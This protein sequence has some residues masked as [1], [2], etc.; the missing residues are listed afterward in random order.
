MQPLEFDEDLCE[1]EGVSPGDVHTADSDWLDDLA[2]FLRSDVMS[3]LLVMIGV[4]CLI[5]EL[6]MPGA[7]V[8]GVIAAVCFVLFFWSESQVAGQITWLA[9]LLFLL[10]LI[11]IGIEVFLV[12]GTGVCGVSGVLLT[13]GGLAV[14]AFGSWP[15]T[16]SDWMGFGHKLWPFSVGIIASVF[17]AV[18]AVRYLKHIPYSLASLKA[19]G[20]AGRTARRRLRTASARV[21][22]AARPRPRGGDAAA[23]GR[24]D[25]VRRAIRGR[26]R[27]GRL[28][29]L[30]RVCR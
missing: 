13:V 3:V 9:V 4:T 22:L 6:K 15:Q 30:G 10:G 8:P 16:T 1:T 24:Q 7:S 28:F 26:G 14:V 2:D 11:L 17:V 20:E 21:G 29:P 23:A 5:I 18:T 25:A 19:P 27:R 12:P